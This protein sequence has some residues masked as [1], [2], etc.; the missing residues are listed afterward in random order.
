MSHLRQQIREAVETILASAPNAVVATIYRSHVYPKTALPCVAIYT[1]NETSELENVTLPSVRTYSRRVDLNI[2]V[3]AE[4]Q[5][6]VEDAVDTLAAAVEVKMAS[7][8]T[9]GGLVVD[10]A[11]EQTNIELHGDTLIPF[12]TA[13]LRYVCW[14]RT[15]A[16]NP[17]GA[18]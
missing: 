6:N 4:S 17:E 5:V 8:P 2:E 14:Y 13:Q 3:T 11:L 7:D 16:D 9:L 12:G 18:Q 1:T 10:A 15:Q